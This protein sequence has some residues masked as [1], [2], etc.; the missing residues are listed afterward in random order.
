ML[1]KYKFI[2]LESVKS[3]NQKRSKGA[4][5]LGENALGCRHTCSNVIPNY[6]DGSGF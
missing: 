2:I 6:Q 5:T 3:E 1:V 4:S